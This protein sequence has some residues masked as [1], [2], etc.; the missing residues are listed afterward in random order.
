MVS[1]VSKHVL[2]VS[3]RNNAMWH[4]LGYLPPHIIALLLGP[5]MLFAIFWG[6]LLDHI[7]QSLKTAEAP[8]GILS[9]ELAFTAAR[10]E[11]IV[12][13]WDSVRKIAKNSLLLDFVFIPLYSTTLALLCIVAGHF[14]QRHNWSGLSTVAVVIA[15]YQWVAGLLD[16]VE[17]WALLRL[18]NIKPPFPDTLPW[19]AGWCAFFKFLLIILALVCFLVA[20][21]CSL[22][23]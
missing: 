12:R 13:S 14:F 23:P 18:L 15:W 16:L 11:A 1:V 22:V 3:E 7:G 6:M 5:F 4:P 9:F 10:S 8:R 21:A 19:L 17:N 2:K 20:V